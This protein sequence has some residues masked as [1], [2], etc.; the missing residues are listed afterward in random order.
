MSAQTPASSARGALLLL[1][2]LL[3]LGTP[4]AHWWVPCPAWS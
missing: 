2:E 4:A 3:A 1:P